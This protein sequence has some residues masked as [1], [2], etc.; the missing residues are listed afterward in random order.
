MTFP[1]VQGIDHTDPEHRLAVGV[2]LMKC[3]DIS[4]P[5]R[6]YHIHMKWTQLCVQEFVD[7]SVVEAK[8]DLQAHQ[9]MHVD[10]SEQGVAKSQVGFIRWIVMP[11]FECLH[12]YAAYDEPLENLKA[13]RNEWQT[14][15]ETGDR[16]YVFTTAAAALTC[17]HR[18]KPSIVTLACH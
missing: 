18:H 8:L 16:Q 9:R 1:F 3:A 7:Q 15:A 10:H 14:R 6:A 2:I 12:A 13:N 5:A 11:L 17:H 4:H